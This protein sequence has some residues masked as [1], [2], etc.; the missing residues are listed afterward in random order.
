MLIARMLTLDTAETIQADVSFVYQNNRW[1][2]GMGADEDE[3]GDFGQLVDL[4]LRQP[5]PCDAD[6][7][8]T[9]RAVVNA[10]YDYLWSYSDWAF[11]NP[12]AVPPVPPFSGANTSSSP[13]YP[14]YS[15]VVKAQSHLSGSQSFTKNLIK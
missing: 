7:G 11:G 6:F 10:F 3:I 4:F 8:A 15:V 13:Q 5:A 1:G 9:Q 2:R 14:A 12:G